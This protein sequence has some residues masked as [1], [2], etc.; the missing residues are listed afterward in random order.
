MYYRTIYLD[1]ILTQLLAL[2]FVVT[3]GSDTGIKQM[4]NN[5]TVGYPK[6]VDCL[7]PAVEFQTDDSQ[8][9]MLI[10]LPKHAMIEDSRYLICYKKTIPKSPLMVRK[11]DFMS[12]LHN[13][14]QFRNTPHYGSVEDV[15]KG[16]ESDF[17][18]LYKKQKTCRV[19]T[20]NLEPEHFQC[21]S[22]QNFLGD[23]QKGSENDFLTSENEQNASKVVPVKLFTKAK[24]IG[25]IVALSSATPESDVGNKKSVKT[26][27]FPAKSFKIS[28]MPLKSKIADS[29]RKAISEI[30]LKGKYKRKKKATPN[31]PYRVEFNT[32]LMEKVPTE[33]P[34]A[35][36][37]KLEQVELIEV[38]PPTKTTKKLKVIR[39]FIT[40]NNTGTGMTILIKHMYTVIKKLRDFTAQVKPGHEL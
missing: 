20:V 4:T 7:L 30:K 11:E 17:L 25:D 27:C 1:Q 31:P 3:S 6:S 5:Q 22:E 37:R 18:N 33:I 15:Q 34:A 32:A 21:L 13:V 28:Q 2:F 39:S 9:V 26:V 16:R 38:L 10:E 19:V 23:Q 36:K 14:E 8:P 35:E 12:L 29:N 40:Q 24:L